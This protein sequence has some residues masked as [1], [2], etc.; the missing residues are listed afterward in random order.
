MPVL[1]A[2][3]V[4]AGAVGAA[5]AQPLALSGVEESGRNFIGQ[6]GWSPHLVSLFV[7]G[8]N[9][10]C[11]AETPQEH[12]RWVSDPL[13]SYLDDGT[14]GLVIQAHPSPGEAAR[15]LALEGLAGI[16]V[17]HEGNSVLRDGLWDQLL[18]A[19]ADAG[20]PFLWG[21]AAD[22]THSRTNIGLSWL[23][24]RL[25]RVDEFA[26]KAALRSGAFYTSNGPAI[27]DIAVDGRTI[28][29]RLP[30]AAEVRW[31][32]SGQFG[33]GPAVVGPV[34]GENHCLQRDAGATESCYTLSE[35]DG[36][37][38]AKAG[39][40]VRALVLAGEGKVAHTMPF[41]ILP[42]GR[43]ENPYPA[44]G[45]WVRSMTHNH[46]DLP[47]ASDD[48][49]TFEPYYQAYRDKGIAAAFETSYSYWE[50]T[51][52][53]HYPAGKV[54]RVDWLEP[55]R[56]PE[57]ASSPVVIHG[58]F[59]R[60]G[61]RVQFGSRPARQVEFLDAHTLRATPPALR[62]GQY[63][64]VVTHRDRFRANLAG[65]YVVQ[66]RKA[67]NAGWTAFTPFS[68][69]PPV[70][71]TLG[72]APA[73]GG[74]WVCTVNGA[75][76]WDGAKWT[77]APVG[78]AGLPNRAV[79]AAATGPDGSTW[80]STGGGIARLDAQGKWQSWRVPAAPEDKFGSPDRYAAIG[81]APD[82]AVWAANRWGAGLVCYRDGAW[83]RLTKRDGL[84]SNDV[85][86]L[87]VDAQGRLWIAAGAG[88]SRWENGKVAERLTAAEG[89]PAGAVTGIRVAADGAMWVTIATGDARE[90]GVV[91]LGKGKPEVFTPANSG[92]PSARVWDLLPD[93]RGGVWFA[94]SNGVARLKPDGRWEHFTPMNSGLVNA[95][96]FSI[97]EAEDGALWFAT[98][99]G[100]CRWL[101]R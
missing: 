37:L 35:T 54:P 40:F 29:L 10:H 84:P 1:I 41:R 76:R 70:A 58:D 8:R 50:V 9:P 66:E 43:L 56:Q 73:P 91:R 77:P 62:P 82:G 93:R 15:I 78:A 92:L 4:A 86:T 96:V 59:F 65:G 13:H 85:R 19:C 31:L 53:G 55:D 47:P 49:A 16:E 2:A 39:R 34:A 52:A 57:G 68:G 24:M 21:Y 6:A 42:G 95:I 11:A 87:A 81:F 98:A 79:Y 23:A 32:K 28:C 61:A 69:G 83:Q 74:V 60:E 71:H 27:A 46:A 80:F 33:C 7:T 20:R 5:H 14:G 25:P 67:A 97:A 72:V 44:A 36:T 45:E 38:D 101:P 64:V 18:T 12:L 48:P 22:D 100:V 94:T 75:Y 63:D 88:L 26:I 90:G 30:E 3:L 51:F 89:L 17:S 99:G